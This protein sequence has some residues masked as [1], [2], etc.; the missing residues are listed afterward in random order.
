MLAATGTLF[1]AVAVIAVA[2]EA[3]GPAIVFGGI[4]AWLIT[5]SA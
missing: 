4:T 2:L 1:G 5:H 3:T